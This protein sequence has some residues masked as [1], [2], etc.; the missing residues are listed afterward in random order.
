MQYTVTTHV[1]Q[2]QL[3]CCFA[4]IDVGALKRRRSGRRMPRAH[5]VA[6]CIEEAGVP[7]ATESD[8]GSDDGASSCNEA[9]EVILLRM[10]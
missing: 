7:H 4:E 1:D 2:V 8:K 6:I 3:L 10:R 9:A 5:A